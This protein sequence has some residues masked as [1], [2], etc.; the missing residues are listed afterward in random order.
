[1]SLFF[2]V[3]CTKKKASSNLVGSAATD[4]NGFYLITNVV[5]GTYFIPNGQV[6]VGAMGYGIAIP[7]A[8]SKFAD[9]AEYGRAPRGHIGIQDHGHEVRYRN[10]KIRPLPIED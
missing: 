10:I 4:A 6:L 5:E 2:R 1:M 7:H 9:Y 8:K 3:R